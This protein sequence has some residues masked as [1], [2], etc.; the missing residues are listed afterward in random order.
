MKTLLRVLLAA[1]VLTAAGVPAPAT[2][3]PGP[4]YYH[5]PTG[6]AVLDSDLFV[7]QPATGNGRVTHSISDLSTW[8]TTKGLALVSVKAYG[9]KGDGVTDDTVA[10]QAAINSGNSLFIPSGVYLTSATLTMSTTASHGQIIRGGGGLAVNGTGTAKTI[11]RPTAAVSTALTIDGTP[12]SGYVQAFGVE[13]LTIDM[14]NMSDVSTS[15]AINQVQ[16]FGGEYMNVR[17]INDGA[18]KRAWKFNAGA[19]TTVL[20][21]CRGNFVEATGISSGNGVST[22]TFIDFDGN[23]FQ[24]TYAVNLRFLGGAFQGAGTTKFKFRFASAIDLNTDV[25]GSGVFLDV[26]ASVNGLWSRAELQGFSGTYMLGT[27]APS[28]MLLD[29]QANYNTYPFNLGVGSF[30][31][32]NQGVSGH[33]SILSGA[34]GADYY[35]DMGRAASDVRLGVASSANDFML[36]TAAGDAAI[37][38][39]NSTALWLGGAQQPQAKVTSTGFNTFGTGTLQQG[40]VIIQPAANGDVLTVRTQAGP[41]I[42]DINTSG[43]PSV[44][45]VNGANFT[46]YSDGFATQK[47]TVNGATGNTTSQGTISGAGINSSSYLTSS[48]P[49]G[50]VGYVAGAGGAVT[51]AT[52]KATGV[53]LNTAT[54]AITMNNA[55]LAASTSVMFVLTNSSIGANDLVL[56]AIKSGATTL[57][58]MTQVEAVAAGSAN[59]V[60]RN[61]SA[62]SLG[63]AVVLNFAVIKGAVS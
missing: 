45:L 34:A 6:Q 59:I 55:A 18:N 63:E 48:S 5:Q 24:G 49:S 61:V 4:T 40:T 26:D 15:I 46:I 33:S 56:V 13:S 27:P 2:A 57:A 16:A 25:E 52:S 43:T 31:F 41:V 12:F 19:Y 28:T 36:G 17:I 11:I 29:Q 51:Q 1:L 37:F 58:Y 23:Q 62:G 3:D 20:T 44:S 35:L 10:L 32:N 60:L 8:M 38:T 9:A 50:G 30:N 54:G 47:F 21:N 14:A 22:L 42:Y 39:L 7:V 53:T